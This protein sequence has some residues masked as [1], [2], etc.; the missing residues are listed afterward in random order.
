MLSVA[1]F[2]LEGHAAFKVQH[3]IYHDIV[4]SQVNINFEYKGILTMQIL[5]SYENDCAVIGQPSL[6]VVLYV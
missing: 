2:C 1:T 3:P 6:C 4:R 5:D